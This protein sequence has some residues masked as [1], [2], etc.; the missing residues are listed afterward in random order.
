[1]KRILC[2]LLALL[3]LS[4]LLVGCK[5]NGEEGNTDASDTVSTNAE[6]VDPYD[7]HDDLGN[8]KFGT[9]DKPVEFTVLQ[10]DSYDPDWCIDPSD[11]ETNIVLNELYNRQLYMEDRFGIVFSFVEVGGKYNG[12]EDFN[13]RIEASIM[14]GTHSYDLAGHYSVGASLL[15]T[16]G[17]AHNLLDVD[18]LDLEK[19]YWPSDLLEANTV[20]NQ[21]YFLTGYLAPSY[22]GNIASVFY[23]K[24]IIESM[25]FEDPVA[26]VDNNQWTF[27]K[28]QQMSVGMYEDTK[29]NGVDREDEF[30]IVFNQGAAPID[31]LSVACGVRIIDI[32][33]EGRLQLSPSCYSTKGVG[34]IDELTKLVSQNNAVFIDKDSGDDFGGVFSSGRSLFTI[35]QLNDMTTFSTK[36]SFEIG[37]V[38][39]PKYDT[40]QEAFYSSIGPQFTL[41]TIPADAKDPDMTGAIL[42][43]LE[44]YSY[45]EVFP[46]VYEQNFKLK[47]SSDSDMSRMVT[48]IYESTRLDPAKT[49]GNAANLYWITRASITGGDSWATRLGKYRNTTW[50]SSIDALNKYLFHEN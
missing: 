18:H 38:P 39:L 22:F 30:G 26:L 24:S 33:S 3:M 9:K 20:N 8:L 2:F 32:N 19:S 28:L 16:N 44:A 27:E 13:K 48:L 5:K 41:F 23:N 49:W 7:V 47:Y 29:N 37:A 12:I 36:A 40:D 34:I 31:A 46:V 4:A 35:G 6:S 50:Q 15:I 45:R 10:W 14:G 42:E 1:M 17:Y 25:S 11:R 43:A 21:M